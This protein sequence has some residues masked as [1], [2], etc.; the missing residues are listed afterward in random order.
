[1]PTDAFQKLKSSVNRGITTIS[2]KTSSSLEKTKIKTHIESLS[3]DIKK[4]FTHI[5]EEAFMMWQ[6]GNKDLSELNTL[7]ECVRQKCAD[8]EALKAELEAIDERDNQILGTSSGEQ[9]S[10]APAP[11]ATSTE[12]PAPAAKRFCTK[13]G[14]GYDTPVKFCRKCGNPMQ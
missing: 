2:V 10:A 14:T 7:F 4:D 8:V 6:A 12:S 3:N 9:P 1:M 5:G 13:C 11:A